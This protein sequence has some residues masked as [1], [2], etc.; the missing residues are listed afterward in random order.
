MHSN[1]SLPSRK[2]LLLGLAAALASAAPLGAQGLEKISF[3]LSASFVAPASM[4]LDTSWEDFENTDA[5]YYGFGAG[6]FCRWDPKDNHGF[7]LRADYLLFGD[8]EKKGQNQTITDSTN[9]VAI[10]ADYIYSFDS[11]N[12]GFYLFAGAGSLITEWKREYT[13]TNVTTGKDSC[14]QSTVGVAAGGGYNFTKN[15]G[16]EIKYTKAFDLELEDPSKPWIKLDADWSW[17]Q[18]SLNWRF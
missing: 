14:T 3:G 2:Y 5:A 7:R 1:L 9:I 8:K 4:S 13:G 12:K 18:V 15:F 11:P 10:M 17:I 16:A 6:V